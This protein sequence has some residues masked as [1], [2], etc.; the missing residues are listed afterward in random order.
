M[1]ST[2]LDLPDPFVALDGEWRAICRRSRRS[3]LARQWALE[4]ALAGI[5]HLADVVP[6]PGVDR[7]PLSAAMVRLHRGGD[8]VAGRALLQ[9][10]VPGLVHLAARWQ[11]ELERWNL[12][13]WE[14]VSRASIYIARLGRGEVTCNGS[15]AWHLVRSIHRDLVDDAQRSRQ[16]GATC[17][18][19]DELDCDAAVALEMSAE[20]VVISG[21]AVLDTL[22]AAASRG[23][24]APVVARTLAHVCVGATVEEACHRAEVGHARYYRHR[25]R[26][27]AVLRRQVL[28]E[29]G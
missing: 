26:A 27:V 14:V 2:E 29:A 6:P 18:T 12:A 24:I 16:A 20:D 17:A 7:E 28:A 5:P 15:V 22:R 19:L 23:A 4:P 13:A 25:Q 3:G 1:V 10:C 21:T 8:E 11:R 9:L